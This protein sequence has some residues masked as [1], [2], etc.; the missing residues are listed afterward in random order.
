MKTWIFSS[1]LP[2]IAGLQTSEFVGQIA[3][4]FGI[5]VNE[6][7]H[8]IFHCRAELDVKSIEKEEKK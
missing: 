5:N 4:D 2:K 1:L 7:E 3:L 6:I 8:T